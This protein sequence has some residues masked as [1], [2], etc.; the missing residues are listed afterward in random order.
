[1]RRGYD[2]VIVGAGPAGSTAA[3]ELS[4]GGFSVLLLDAKDFPRDK[5]CGGG[6]TP[7]AW[8][9]LSVPIDD[10]VLNRATSVQV[11]AGSS[12]STRFHSRSSSIWMVRR[13]DLDLRLVEAAQEAGAEFRQGEMVRSLE[14][15]PES[16]VETEG[17]RYRARVV[18]GADGAE[19]RVARWL[20][21][22]RP[23]RWMVA[24]ED[25]MEVAGDPLKGEAVVDLAVPSGYAWVF[26]KGDLYNVGIGTFDR[27]YAPKLRKHLGAFL[28][29]MGLPW[30]SA[31]A[32]RGHRIP[33]GVA[34]GPLHSGGS[35]VVGDAAG[36]ADPFYAE[37]ISYALLTGRLASVA[38]SSYLAGRTAD[39]S[40]YT[41]QVKGTVGADARLW[42]A[43]A[44]VVH[45]FPALSVRLL[46]S[47]PG[48]QRL[49]ERTIAGE[50]GFSKVAADC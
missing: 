50:A 18:I 36:V 14:P 5:P 21:I 19:S 33:V 9:Q 39:L 34:P 4:R 49:V 8:R 1:M 28:D 10:L 2:V 7:R 11:R 25:E 47:S 35:L 20:G 16:W 41:H 22:S 31:P 13:R 43:T 44:G 29:G 37:G 38:V 23:T 45:R 6:L 48:L 32:P 24:L 27:R 46:A 17:E 42:L 15:G 26:P 12:F 40:S 3:R 30:R